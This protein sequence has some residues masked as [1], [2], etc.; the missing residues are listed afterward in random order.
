MK[1]A[2]QSGWSM[3]CNEEGNFVTLSDDYG[4]YIEVTM[5]PEGG[6]SSKTYD[7]ELTLF[8]LPQSVLNLLDLWLKVTD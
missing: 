6:I 1:T 7:C 4:R 2:R 8:D 5:A 3:T